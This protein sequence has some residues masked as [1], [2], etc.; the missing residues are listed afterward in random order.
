MWALCEKEK[1]KYDFAWLDETVKALLDMGIQPFLTLAYGNPIY[2]DKCKEPGGIGASPFEN[3]E[4]HSAF[5]K[6]AGALAAHFADRVSHYEVW[7]EPDGGDFL[8]LNQKE[9]TWY[10]EYGKLLRS[11]GDVIRKANLKA[12]IV[13]G[14][15]IMCETPEPAYR[16][17][18]Q[19]GM[20][21]YVDVVSY[22]F[23]RPLPEQSS[24]QIRAAWKATVERYVPGSPVWM[25]ESGLPSFREHG[26]Q[27]ALL[28]MRKYSE[29]IQAKWLSRRMIDYLSDNLTELVLYFRLADYI[30]FETG[31]MNHYSVLRY[32]DGSEKPSYYALQ[33]VC[34]L[35]DG[36]TLPSDEVLF[37]LRN[38]KGYDLHTAYM[39]NSTERHGFIRNGVPMLIYWNPSDVDLPYAPTK[40]DLRYWLPK[41]ASFERPVAIDM[42]TGNV[43]TLEKHSI[44]RFPNGYEGPRI[45]HDVPLLDYPVA[46]F[47]F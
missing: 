6:F 34:S 36:K 29:E 2:S 31:I 27:G 16:I 9:A 24:R 4:A 37:E 11:T 26:N 40:C 30:R 45:L 44:R 13:C 28:E 42:L 43:Y 14:A 18:S 8:P 20:S 7:N 41:G 17:L 22:H 25:D 12:K 3:D 23:Y 38:P 39:L 21:D 32:E 5:V 15:F 46:W 1:G 19:D 33:N 35:L 10:S 47:C